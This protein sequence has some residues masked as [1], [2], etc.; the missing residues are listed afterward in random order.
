M[1]M[2]KDEQHNGGGDILA[3]LADALTAKRCAAKS[4][5]GAV[6]KVARRRGADFGEVLREAYTA[7]CGREADC[8]LLRRVELAVR[9]EIAARLM[10]RRV[11]VRE[12]FDGSTDFR[13]PVRLDFRAR[14]A[15]GLLK[16]YSPGYFTKGEFCQ[17]VAAALVRACI[18]CS[19][20][21]EDGFNQVLKV[22]EWPKDEAGRAFVRVG[23]PCAVPDVMAMPDDSRAGFHLIGDA[24]RV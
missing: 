4:M 11:E 8:A 7:A 10:V 2:K 21:G 14:V 15:A 12:G 22:I 16:R 13:L 20:I 24:E 3:E 1:D 6:E 23:S 5:R 19:A 18:G 17:A 9:R